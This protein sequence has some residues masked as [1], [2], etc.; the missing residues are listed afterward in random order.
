MMK[1]SLQFS[2]LVLILGL[3]SSA[4]QQESGVEVK[5]F[6]HE[7]ASGGTGNISMTELNN[8]KIGTKIL[9][10]TQDGKPR[11][12]K[13]FTFFVD[14]EGSKE[15]YGGPN[16]TDFVQEGALMDIKKLHPGDEIICGQIIYMTPDHKDVKLK[17]SY[18]LTVTN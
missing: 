2:F 11:L 7:V 18:S 5:V 14:L 9:K 17:S 8:I 10:V 3:F 6:D 12:V 4:K 15:A 13:S 16:S 1:E